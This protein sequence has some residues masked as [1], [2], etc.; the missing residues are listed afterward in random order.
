MQ[1]CSVAMLTD[2]A[3]ASN[4]L[5]LQITRAPGAINAPLFDRFGPNVGADIP[6]RTDYVGALR[7]LLNRFG[8]DP[9]LSIIVFTLDEA[10]TARA[11]SPAREPLSGVEA[12]G[13]PGGSRQSRR[14]D[15]LSRTD[16][17]DRRVLQ[18]RQL[19]R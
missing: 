19:Q 7:P 6:T 14:H 16:H 17:R 12:R 3:R 15:A 4:R 5:V 2:G 9:A 18:H 13:R 10:R 11:K 1:T 8:N